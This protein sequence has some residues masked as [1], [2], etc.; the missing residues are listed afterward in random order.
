MR[1]I[2]LSLMLGL[3]PVLAQAQSK[4]PAGDAKAAP[5]EAKAA[6]AEAK[7]AADE[8][9]QAAGDLKPAPDEV[10]RVLNYYFHGKGQGPV[11]MEAKL[12]RDIKRDGED[13]N[14]CAGDVPLQALKKGESVYLWMAYMVPSGEETQNIVV[15]FEKGGV[16][17]MV[18]S[19]Q[20]SS[21]LRNRS[22]LK[23]SLDKPGPWKL[24][25]VR[26]TGAGS[27]AL[28]TI[29]VAVK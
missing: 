20:V 5:G 10:R 11:L 1:I 8:A 28:G 16:T 25:V 19:L 3:T 13:K 24:R 29:D 27:E 23:M 2:I 15:L 9:K 14:E 21:Q 17:R 12:C 6:Q 22:W 7:A 18:E 4:A 26:D